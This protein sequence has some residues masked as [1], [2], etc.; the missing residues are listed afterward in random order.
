MVT[1]TQSEMDEMRA[2]IAAGVLPSNSIEK[3]L[4]EEARHVFGYDY[5]RDANG[6]PIEAGIGS[7][8]QPSRN[9]VEAYRK[10]GKEEA[11]YHEN[12]A[13]MERELAEYEA[14]QNSKRAA[15]R[16]M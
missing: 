8:Q 5:R 9:S 6:T 1:K 11:S 13:R 2:Q 16:R 3:Y 7:K 14:K 4:E 15:A 10:W 12:L